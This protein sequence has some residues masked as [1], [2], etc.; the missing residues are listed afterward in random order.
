MLFPAYSIQFLRKNQV[1]L[2]VNGPDPPYFNQK[3]KSN[4]TKFWPTG[5]FKIYYFF[6]FEKKKK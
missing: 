2:L 4:I 6:I 5:F 3:Q 1:N